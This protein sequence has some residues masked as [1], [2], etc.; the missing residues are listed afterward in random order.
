VGR[1]NNY[2]KVKLRHGGRRF[3]S[4]GEVGGRGEEE[5]TYLLIQ[6]LLYSIIFFFCVLVVVVVV[7]VIKYIVLEKKKR[8]CTGIAVLHLL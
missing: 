4:C 8:N 7:V 1:R 6:G 5:G 2:E 3:S